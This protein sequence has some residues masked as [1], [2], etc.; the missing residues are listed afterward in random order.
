MA[1]IPALGQSDFRMLREAGAGYVDKTAFIRE[2]LADPAQVL[3]FPRPRRFGKTIN[4]ST[5]AWFLEQRSEDLSHLFHDLAVW[6]DPTARAHFQRHPVV[7][8]TFKDI[9][10]HTYADAL[11]GIRSELQRIYRKQKALLDEGAVDEY[12]RPRF[13]RILRG[14]ATEE[15]CRRSLKDLSDHL[16]LRHGRGVVI[17]IDEYD[18]PIQSGFLHG[19]FDEVTLLFRNLLS[20]ALKDNP[21]LFKGVLTGVLRIARENL[22]SGLNNV[23]V[24][25]LLSDRYSAAFGF[26]P[27]EVAAILPEAEDTAAEG[28]ARL[29]D[30]EAWYDGYRFGGQVI[31]NPWSI[32]SYLHSGRLGPHWVNTSSNDLIFDLLAR[33]GLG[34]SPDMEALLSGDSIEARIDENIVL[35]DLDALP[36]AVWTFLLFSGYLKPV[37]LRDELGAR[38][39]SLAIPNLEVKVSYRD[40]FQSWI[41][42]GLSGRQTVDALCSALLRGDAPDLEALLERLLLTVMSFQDPPGREPEKLYHG[43]ILGLLV[44]LEGRHEVRSNRES[45]FGRAD[46]LVRGRAPGQPG[47]VLELKVPRRGETPE[48]ALLAAARQVRDRRYA[49]ELVAAGASPVHELAVVFD[50]K[51]VWARRV[52]DV[53]AEAEG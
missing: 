7:F 39:A 49:A 11:D 26:T 43:I 51:R 24:H 10:A 48:Q 12:A 15:D 8:V 18:T 1:F 35:R 25:S 9:K 53:L 30:I 45:G 20:A 32:L 37:A 44:Q 2:L 19:F 13:E 42:R 14:E 27:E 22:F 33:R 16:A 5:L 3:L 38:Y 21:S 41:E 4:L 23:V 6:Q 52:E 40:V 17:L 31:Y 47:V 46:V 28:A 50:G 36:D 34:L 29:A